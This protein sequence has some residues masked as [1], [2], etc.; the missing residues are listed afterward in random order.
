MAKFK[1]RKKYESILTAKE[2]KQWENLELLSERVK[3]KKDRAEKQRKAYNKAHP[4]KRDRDTKTSKQFRA[5]LKSTTPHIRRTAYPGG[6]TGYHREGTKT[7][8]FKQGPLFTLPS[9]KKTRLWKPNDPEYQ[10]NIKGQR[11]G[12]GY[13]SMH[14][15]QNPTGKRPG[16][17]Q[18]A[19]ENI[20][21]KKPGK[22]TSA[23]GK[24][25]Y[26]RR[27]NRSN[28]K[29]DQYPFYP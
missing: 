9:G 8:A 7:G 5:T 21:A 27:K 11:G 22:R 10:L 17:S 12:K 20:K 1:K 19:D 26:E 29:R 2:L 4:K 3:F 15:E 14:R 24:V 18:R 13:Y 28:R 23:S 25:Y 16:T 6:Y